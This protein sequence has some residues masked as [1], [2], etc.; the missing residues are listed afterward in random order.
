MFWKRKKAPPPM[1]IPY[2]SLYFANVGGEL[3]L[4]EELHLGYIRGYRWWRIVNDGQGLCLASLHTDMIWEESV[5]ADCR[6]RMT[7]KPGSHESK[8]PDP[9]CS[10]GL[11]A[12][13]PNHVLPEWERRTR[14]VASASGSI[15]MSGRVIVCQ[16][17]YKAEHARI[18][19][20]VLIDVACQKDCDVRP[21]RVELPQPWTSYAAWCPEHD[22]PGHPGFVSVDAD[23]WLRHA[24]TD[25]N[26][27]Y[28][29]VEFI[30][31]ALLEEI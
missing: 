26:E 4:P 12:Q 14:A 2:Q 5:I 11:Y 15:L 3:L 9:H 25:L 13:T 1:P 18:E 30:S 31:P 27:R 7:G 21:T 8:A 19:S 10:C 23:V 22:P 28:P 29:N 17:G 16:K 6:P 24:V 20:P